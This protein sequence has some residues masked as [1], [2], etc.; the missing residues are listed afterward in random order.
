[1]AKS[2]FIIERPKCRYRFEVDGIIVM[3]K[4][5]KPRFSLTTIIQK[6]IY[7]FFCFIAFVVEV[8]IWAWGLHWI[9]GDFDY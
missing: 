6:I 1:M 4:K 8:F 3:Q 5:S 9:L 2:T 7:W